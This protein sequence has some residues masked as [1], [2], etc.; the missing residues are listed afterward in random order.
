MPARKPLAAEA[1]EKTAAAPAASP[2]ARKA[3]QHRKNLERMQEELRYGHSKLRHLT[4]KKVEQLE[5]GDQAIFH[6]MIVEFARGDLDY[7][8]KAACLGVIGRLDIEAGRPVLIDAVKDK[9]E[10]VRRASIRSIAHLEYAPA[11]P[12]IMEMIKEE[13]FKENNTLLISAI[14][15]LARLKHDDT[16]FFKQ[17]A[18]DQDTHAEIK[19]T[20]ALYFGSV[21]SQT[22]KD[23]LVKWMRDEDERPLVRAYA[24]NSLGKLGDASAIPPLKET[25]EEIHGLTN[26]RQRA[27][28]GRLRLNAMMALLR[29][30]E[31]SVEKEVLAMAR[32][33]DANVR[34]NTVKQMGDLK[35]REGL[36]SLKY[37]ADRDPS[38][39][40]K[41]AA[42]RAVKAME[43]DWE[44]K[45]F[46]VLEERAKNHRSEKVRRESQRILKKLRA[47]DLAAEEDDKKK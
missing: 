35:L 14:H 13:D 42:R 30:G 7:T 23:S 45:W 46:H 43:P 17:K 21:G 9:N 47:G 26:P 20:I 10:D 25:L 44:P 1:F 38:R 33:N 11:A 3:E 31:K 5:E 36:E 29:L 22:S 39:S 32:D 2:D 37:M 6:D 41:L 28:L 19:Q 34:L 15:T 27:Q 8:V 40:V 4:L 16:A 12:A 24:A 18:E